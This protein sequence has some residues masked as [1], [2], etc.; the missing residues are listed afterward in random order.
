MKGLP[1][2]VSKDSTGATAQRA[3]CLPDD[4]LLFIGSRKSLLI[5]YIYEGQTNWSQ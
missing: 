3:D 4:C 2:G 1:I 5:Q